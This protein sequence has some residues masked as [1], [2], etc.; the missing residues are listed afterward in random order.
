MGST[1]FGNPR[2]LGR[3]VPN[4]ARAQQSGSKELKSGL[5]IKSIAPPLKTVNKCHS[6]LVPRLSEQMD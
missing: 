6:S 1:V 5:N 4:V 2:A 3:S